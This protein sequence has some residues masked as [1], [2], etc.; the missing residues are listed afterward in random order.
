MNRINLLA[1]MLTVVYIVGGA[2]IAYA[3]S[4]K[5]ICAPF[6]PDPYLYVRCMDEQK[7]AKKLAH[8]PVPQSQTQRARS[9]TRRF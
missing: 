6:E 8:E 1:A 3:A 4:A 7:G 2:A 9:G 5:Q